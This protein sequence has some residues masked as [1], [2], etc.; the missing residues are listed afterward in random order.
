VKFDPNFDTIAQLY[1]STTVKH[2]SLWQLKAGFHQKPG[3]KKERVGV[4]G[5]PPSSQQQGDETSSAEPRASL[6]GASGES[7]EGWGWGWGW[8]NCD[9]SAP[10]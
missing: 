5:T 10:S 3:K 8:P 2:E 1:Y 7:Y 9:M 4:D 6:P